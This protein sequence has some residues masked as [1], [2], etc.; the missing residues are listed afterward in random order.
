MAVFVKKAVGPIVGLDI[1]S[2]YI[3]VIEARLNRGRAEVT[4]LAVFPTPSDVMD[5]NIVLDPQ[6]LGQTIKQVLQQAG[7]SAKRVVS[8][9]A[10]QQSLV[11]R[12]IPVPKMTL[13]ELKETMKWEVERHVPFA[14]DQ[15]VVDFE[16]LSPPE[17]IPDGENMEVLL[18]VAQED[19][20]NSHVAA[21]QAAGLQP[22]AI[23][24]EP[25]ASSRA[26]LELANGGSGTT[27]TVAV[28]DLGANTSDISIFRD[29][30]IG[31]TRSTPLAGNALSRA[32][33]E[34][35]GQPLDQAERLKKDLGRVPEGAGGFALPELDTGF[36]GGL[37]AEPTASP[38]GSPLGGEPE[39]GSQ[40]YDFAGGGLGGGRGFADTPDGPVFDVGAS[41]DEAAQQGRR[42][43]FDLSEGAGTELGGF[44]ISPGGSDTFGTPALPTGPAPGQSEEEYLQSQV[45]DAMI[46]ILG[47]LVTELRRSIDY[48]R[49]QS[50]GGVDRI[51]ICG[52]TAK[53][54]GL[55]PFL[56]AQLG[57]PVEVADPMRNVTVVA[58]A[59]AAYLAEVAP[60]FPV[61]LGLA[62]R[63]M[64]DDAVP[65]KAGGK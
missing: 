4:A 62:V 16:P 9:V 46:P 12:I 31:F 5:N 63:E 65:R 61:S 57:A 25:L 64:L 2:N 32:I 52:G 24:I 29:G 8:S 10:G 20:I 1:G 13:T 47:E 58:K 42:Q 59:D 22:V 35:V 27:G 18:A 26:L 11:V 51:Y 3:K 39:S 44:S 50:A 36:G 53:L 19:L 28:V 49:S 60:V 56:S 23:D 38:F 14:S 6:S 45:A 33:A 54:P 21:L 48:F 37:G 55:A 41:P 15:T 43:V 34:H 7:I 40:T 30:L 17:S